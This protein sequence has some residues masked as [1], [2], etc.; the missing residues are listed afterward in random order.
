MKCVWLIFC[1]STACRHQMGQYWPYKE[2]P[3]ASPYC[4]PFLDVWAFVS[5]IDWMLIGEEAWVPSTALCSLGVCDGVFAPPLHVGSPFW[6]QINVSLQLVFGWFPLLSAA[7]KQ[8][9]LLGFLFKCEQPAFKRPFPDF[10][11][12]QKNPSKSVYSKKTYLQ[13]ETQRGEK[14]HPATPARL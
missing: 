4:L 10:P 1:Q 7:W 9:P 13:K 11:G 12:I 8:E 3:I 14:V 6:K 2:S 5:Q